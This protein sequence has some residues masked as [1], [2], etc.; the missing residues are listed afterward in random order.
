MRIAVVG[1]SHGKL[2]DIYQ[3]I[4]R[5]DTESKKMGELA[6]EL[7]L[8]CGDFQATR[9]NADLY[10]MKTPAK[11]RLLGDFHNYYAGRKKA[12]VLTIVIGGNHESMGHMWDCYH[13]GWLAPNI[14][15]LG[16]AGC[17]LVDGWLRIAGS[18]GIFK[19][20]DWIKGSCRL[21]L[22]ISQLIGASTG[23]FE[24][25]PFTPSALA[26][27]YHTRQYD[28]ARLMELQSNGPKVD[29][30]MSHDWPRGI[31]KH[32]DTEALLRENP[33]FKT[34][35]Y[36]NTLGSP[37]YEV[38]LNTLKPKRWCAG[39]MHVRFTA[40]VR[41]D[42]QQPLLSQTTKFLALD[43]PGEGRAFLEV[44]DVPTPEAHQ[45]PPEG[46]RHRTP[47]LFFD[48]HWLAIVR[49]FAP[50]L[51]LTEHAPPLHPVTQAPALIAE[52][53][54]W[55]QQNVG[56]KAVRDVQV[57]TQ[58]AT[59]TRS[60]GGEEDKGVRPRLYPNPQTQA[61]CD[62][63]GIPNQIDQVVPL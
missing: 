44:I 20:E 34:S 31:E 12:P 54:V 39:H 38:L 26:S 45:Q 63:L 23:H 62:M 16:Y 61:F 2:D 1:C 46:T 7:L 30:M 4:R 17:V 32:G 35:I 55:V 25:I 11:H 43:K 42:E 58:T 59:P 9:C 18:S 13:G 15:F 28:V 27:A 41:H 3:A 60:Y 24:R 6:V 8:C 48:P 53:L 19:E 51:P 52:A 37:V 21:R 47:E 40:E 36:S 57:F 29:I 22:P 14:Y 50:F 49:A 56:L 10:T 5:V 33:R